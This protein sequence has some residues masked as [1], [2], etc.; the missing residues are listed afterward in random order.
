MFPAYSMASLS[1][2]TSI[3]GTRNAEAPKKYYNTIPD[4]R[5]PGSCAVIGFN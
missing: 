4:L 3:Y 2:I 1:R 5:L